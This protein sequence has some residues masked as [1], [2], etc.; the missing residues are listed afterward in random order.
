MAYERKNGDGILF[1]NEN[2]KPGEKTP[3]YRGQIEWNGTTYALA[4]WV[5]T[6][7]NEKKYMA[8]KMSEIKPKEDLQPNT[9]SNEELPF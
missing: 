4:G 8:I 1:R 2:K 6:D 7:R 3:D 9:E 5:N